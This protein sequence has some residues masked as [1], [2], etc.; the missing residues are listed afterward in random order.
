MKLFS[1]TFLFC[2][3]VVLSL[4]LSD[5][6]SAAKFRRNGNASNDSGTLGVNV[7]ENRSSDAMLL[8][9]EIHGKDVG[10]DVVLSGTGPINLTLTHEMLE[11]EICD[12][13]AGT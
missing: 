10:E 8:S 3:F 6:I 2:F 11:F 7:R 9:D 5:S 13:C 4:E 12:N 1:Q